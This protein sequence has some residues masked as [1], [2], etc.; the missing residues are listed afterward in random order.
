MHLHA[1]PIS[2]HYVHKDYKRLDQLKQVYLD[3]TG[4]SLYAESQ[5]QNHMTMLLHS[6]YGNPHSDNPTSQISTLIAQE[7]RN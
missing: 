6:V 1:R 3:Y 7:A 5:V 2:M 4:S